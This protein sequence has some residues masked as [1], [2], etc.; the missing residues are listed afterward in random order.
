M[1]K[2]EVRMI[3]NGAPVTAIVQPKMTLL[4]FLRD[5][6]RL[7]GTKCGCGAGECGTCVVIVNGEAKKSCLQQMNRLEGATIQTIEGL[8]VDS[9][10]PLQRAFIDKGAIQCGFCT[11]G[12]IM[13][14][15]AL[16]DRD[17]Y[18]PGT[19]S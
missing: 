17:P 5:H 12:M 7:T 18:R 13:A 1:R 14:A 19:T 8:S 3:V 15:K 16:L 11:P 9:L 2:D 4:R 6:L 10:H